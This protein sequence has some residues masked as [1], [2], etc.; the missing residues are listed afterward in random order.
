MTLYDSSSIVSLRYIQDSILASGNGDGHIKLWNLSNSSLFQQLNNHTNDVTCLKLSNNKSQLASSSLDKT[1]KLWDLNTYKLT[2]TL[3]DTN[4]EIVSC[5]EYIN[6]TI[7][8]SGSA[9]TNVVYI[10]DLEKG[11]IINNLH[12]QT[13]KS[14]LLMNNAYL[15]TGDDYLYTNVIIWRISDWKIYSQSS[16][17]GINL[18]QIDSNNIAMIRRYQQLDTWDIRDSIYDQLSPSYYISLD[19]IDNYII[20]ACNTNR[21]IE[22]WNL[23]SRECIKTI[24]SSHD[25][26]VIESVL[27]DVK[28]NTKLNL[29]TIPTML[30][31]Q[32]TVTE[33]TFLS[34]TGYRDTSIAANSSQITQTDF[35]KNEILTTISF[36]STKSQQITLNPFSDNVISLSA[37]FSSS[38]IQNMNISD[39][40]N[41]LENKT[42]SFDLSQPSSQLPSSLLTS[43]KYDIADCVSNCSNQGICKIKDGSKFIC[44]CDLDYSGTKCEIDLRPCSADPCLNY[45]Q[46]EN[47]QNGTQFNQEFNQ[48]E[49]NYIDFKCQCK[50]DKYYGKR[51]ES[52]I[53]LCQ[54]ET[55][56]GN[57]VCKI[58]NENEFNQTILC[59]CFGLNSFEGKKCETKSSKMKLR[60]NTIKATAWIAI[61]SV[62]I[63]Y[64][65]IFMMDIHKLITNKTSSNSSNNKTIKNN[66]RRTNEP[67]KPTKLVYVP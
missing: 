19:I 39:L 41:N 8:A 58:L 60:E 64:S 10:W 12:H 52:K 25:I 34:S 31:N 37:V 43:S 9:K 30:T 38:N 28:L 59:K 67:A 21:L 47:I 48:Y 22:I 57:G 11:K 50:S 44:Q 14:L 4:N 26:V 42:F 16:L 6:E 65:F 18:R 66:K 46:C 63:F 20:A 32:N 61:S 54:N 62:C 36:D 49:N 27:D 35:L 15:I 24:S 3:I 53:N 55:C 13:V 51:C 33:I 29:T 5:I 56:S 45:L 1:I 40:I 17:S 7:L 2:K 23:T